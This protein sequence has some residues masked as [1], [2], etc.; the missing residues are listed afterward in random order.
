[1]GL[2]SAILMAGIRGF[3][4]ALEAVTLLTSALLLRHKITCV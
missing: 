2:R 1:M 3:A 4:C